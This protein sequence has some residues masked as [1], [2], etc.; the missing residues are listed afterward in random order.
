MLSCNEISTLYVSQTEGNDDYSGYLP[1]ADGRGCGPF[2]TLERAVDAVLSMRA[3][4]CFQPVTVAVM[5]D[6]CLAKPLELGCRHYPQAC[7]PRFSESTP[8]ES[9]TFQ[10]YGAKRARLIGGKKLTGFCNDTFMGKDCLSVRVPEVA[11]GKWDF[12]DLYVNGKRAEIARYPASGTFTA[13][14]S[15]FPLESMTTSG[16]KWFLA[17]KED[18]CDVTDIESAVINFDHHWVDEHTPVESYDRET[19]KLVFRYRSTFNISTEY[20]HIDAKGHGHTSEFHYYVTDT[21]HGFL[22]PGDWFLD[23]NEG[24]LYYIPRDASETAGTVE[25]FAPTLTQLVRVEGTPENKAYAIRFRNLS[26]FCTKGD[27]VPNAAS[28]APDESVG[29]PKENDRASDCQAAFA[30]PG[31]IYFRYADLCSVTDCDV[32]C[33][34]AYAIDVREGCDRTRVENCR[35]TG[36]GAGGIKIFGGSI[37]QPEEMRSSYATIRNNEIADIGLRYAQGIGIILSHSAFNEIEGNVIHDTYYSGIS[38]GWV[39]GY[40]ENISIGNRIVKNHVYNIG[41]G[42]RSRLSDLGGIYCLARQ[43]GT[44]IAENRI[45]DI[46]CSVYL[47]CG[48]HADEGSSYLTVEKNLIYNTDVSMALHFGMGNT[49]RNNVFANASDYL[50]RDCRNESHT[51]LLI[52]HNILVNN[53]KPIYRGANRMMDG[54]VMHHNLIWNSAKDPK[55]T[56]VDFDTWQK[57]YGKDEGS[58]FADPG[59]AAPEKGDFSLPEN[60]PAFSVGFEKWEE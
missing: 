17:H 20:N 6:Y 33:T 5:G 29:D 18:L 16:S 21:K 42:E 3:A 54:A 44:V 23:R 46:T 35:L 25:V 59:F 4:S 36:L 47:A 7:T 32:T 27:Y 56:D 1:Q 8:F 10:S 52:E 38:I 19:G 55:I 39:W 48:L 9:V 11:E 45:H 24:I 53:G 50:I 26:F 28:W 43:R 60:S 13:V 57:V 30:A 14:T 2:R 15:E 41:R 34:G 49:V 37:Q 40:E 58:I 12:T 22:R 31:A 51:K